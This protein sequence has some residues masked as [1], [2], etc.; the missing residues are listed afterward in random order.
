MTKIY[1]NSSGQMTKIYEHDSCM[2]FCDIFVF[3]MQQDMGNV[4]G[5]QVA[6]LN[7]RHCGQGVPELIIRAT[8]RWPAFTSELACIVRNMSPASKKPKTL[9]SMLESAIEEQLATEELAPME[10]E[11][12]APTGT[13]EQPTLTVELPTGTEE[14]ATG[15]EEQAEDEKQDEQV[16]VNLPGNTSVPVKKEMDPPQEMMLLRENGMF[17]FVLDGQDLI[18]VPQSKRRRVP[19]QMVVY[20][21]DAGELQKEFP[22]NLMPWVTHLTWSLNMRTKVFFVAK[23]SEEP[24]YMRI[25]DIVKMQKE[26]KLKSIISKG[27]FQNGKFKDYTKKEMQDKPTC[28][29]PKSDPTVEAVLRCKAFEENVMVV[30][31]FVACQEFMCRHGV[32][33]GSTNMGPPS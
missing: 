29:V 13:E 9:E 1:Q 33:R 21:S 16:M 23:S 6:E 8:Q 15:T 2:M 32:K 22:E 7:V 26:L 4:E 30:C 18:A 31:S 24:Q 27:T 5:L 25:G 28:W 20:G 10:T 14:Q 3:A 19:T 12:P 17:N 11:E